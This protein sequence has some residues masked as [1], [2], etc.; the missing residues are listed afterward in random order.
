MAATNSLL[1][2]AL[3]GRAVASRCNSHSASHEEVLRLSYVSC[4]QQATSLVIHNSL[5]V[6]SGQNIDQPCCLYRLEACLVHLYILTEL[7][8]LLCNLRYIQPSIPCSVQVAA[9]SPPMSLGTQSSQSFSGFISIS[10]QVAVQFCS[11][12]P[13]WCTDCGHAMRLC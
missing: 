8:P 3:N 5:K 13:R 12:Y 11:K 2:A 1:T 6:A 9:F 4:G 7:N 10:K